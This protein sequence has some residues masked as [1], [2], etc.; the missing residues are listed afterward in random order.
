[1]LPVYINEDGQAEVC[2]QFL[3]LSAG[4]D[5][6]LT[7]P[8]G[9][10]FNQ[11]YGISL[12]ETAFDGQIFFVYNEYE[13]Q[14]LPIEGGILTG[15]LTAPCYITANYGYDDPND[16]EATTIDGAIISGTGINGALYFKIIEED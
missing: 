10:G 15:N 14:Y 9:L 12:P 8:L 1:M 7:G 16:E 6:I 2:N 5:Y 11:N 4:K 3:P 13:P